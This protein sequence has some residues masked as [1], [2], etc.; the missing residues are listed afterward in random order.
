MC[1]ESLPSRLLPRD[2][3]HFAR[4]SVIDCTGLGRPSNAGQKHL[5]GDVTDL[6][7][8]ESHVRAA[9]DVRH[10]ERTVSIIT[11]M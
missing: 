1:T 4:T 11:D 3:L 6:A 10:S 7:G 8:L 5:F 2:D 9:G